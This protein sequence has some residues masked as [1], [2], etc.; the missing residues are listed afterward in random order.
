MNLPHFLTQTL[1]HNNF[2]T[3]LLPL[4]S[5]LAR[6][7]NTRL[8]DPPSNNTAPYQLLLSLIIGFWALFVF[9]LLRRRYPKIY[10]ANHHFNNSLHL[11]TLPNLLFAWLPIVYSISDHAVLNHA[12]LDALVFLRFFSMS[13]KILC[14]CLAT[15][16]FV[17]SPIRYYFTGKVDQDYPSD[18]EGAALD[19]FDNSFKQF[20]WMYTFFTYLFT[21]VV[22]YFLYKELLNIIRLRQSYL[23]KQNSITDKTIKLSGIPKPLRDEVALKNMIQL[24]GI[25]SVDQVCLVRQWKPLIVLFHRRKKVLYA[26]E[27]CWA[28]YFHRLGIANCA[29][30]ARIDLNVVGESYSMDLIHRIELAIAEESPVRPTIR[31]RWRGPRVDAI[32]HYTL[33]L[34]DIDCE[35]ELARNQYYPPSSTAFVTLASPAMTQILAQA[36]LDP[37]VHRYI[38]TLAPAPHDIVWDNVCLSRAERN[39]RIVCVTLAF[40]G[41]SAL[42]VFPVRYLANLLNVHS[43]SRIWP[44]LGAFLS[45]HPWAAQVVTGLLPPYIFAILNTVMPFLCIWISNRQGFTSHGEIELSAV[46]KNFFYIFVNLFLVFTLFGTAILSDTSKIAYQLAQSLRDLSLFYVDLILLQGLGMFPYK[47]L[48]LGNLLGYP[49]QSRFWCKTPRDWHRLHKPPV[50]DFGLN[51][52]QPILILIISVVYSVMLS[53][54]LLAGLLYFLVGY[55]V[56]KYQLLYACVHPPHST[57]KVWILIFRRVI[58]GLL[59][60]Q[61]TMVGTLALQLAYICAAF[62][63]PLPILT[64]LFMWNF[65]QNFVPLLIFLALKAI[66]DER[67]EGLSGDLLGDDCVLGDLPGEDR[68]QS[69][70]LEQDLER[71]PLYATLD[72]R[73]EFHASYEF[74]NLVR[75]LEGPM[76]ASDG[77]VVMSILDGKVV[78]RKR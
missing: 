15:A 74:P 6:N 50:F 28:D 19:Y 40:G 68:L 54:I 35:I 38:S 32:S 1:S 21:I 17:I 53:K 22:A 10:G 55:V 36:V 12:G 3:L 51:L 65:E 67:V 60:F 69:D 33:Q 61:I 62:L 42:M 58:L 4:L 13:I 5:S 76:I 59:I 23:G 9:S 30:L 70:S 11:P 52:P 64:L 26:L 48:L 49:L 44:R 66:Q 45:H 7:N 78:M 57:G 75:P 41:V 47:L 37:H 24:L 20:Y 73:R 77:D 8:Y 43:I 63:T 39:A 27:K 29:D 71:Q 34:H 31:P 56:C 14:G 25:A 2:P 72:E 46:S 18:D 16:L